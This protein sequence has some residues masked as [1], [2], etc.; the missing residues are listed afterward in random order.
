MPRTAPSTETVKPI[1]RKLKFC[2]NPELN[3]E[4]SIHKSIKA[5]KEAEKEAKMKVKMDKVAAKAQ[6]D[7]EILTGVQHC[8]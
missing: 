5:K 6:S 8:G 1:D 2:T 3:P 7:M 4:S